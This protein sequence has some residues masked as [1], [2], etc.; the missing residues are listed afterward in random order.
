MNLRDTIVAI[1]TPLGRGGLGI[2]RL[3]GKESRNI[4]ERILRF[5]QGPHWR[6]WS[7]Q[8]AELLD[9]DDAVIDQVVVSF[10][11]APR[12]Y[13][14]EDVVEIACHGAPVV[15]RLCLERAIEHGARIAEPGEF[16]LRAYTN[17]RIDLPRAEAIR[18]LIDATTLYQARVAAQQMEGSVSRR[19]APIKEQLL[20]LISLLEAGIDFAEDD[21]SVAPPA[22]I[23]RRLAPIQDSLAKLVAS[24]A[25]GK[26]VFQGFTLAIAG[27]PNVGKSSLF[28][29]LLEQDR[30]IVTAIPGTTRD[31]VSES[32]TIAG[33]PVKLM[34][35]AGIREGVDLVENLGIERTYQA[36]ADADLTLLVFD[37][38]E[39]VMEEDRILRNKLHD[40][41]PLLVGNKADLAPACDGDFLAVSALTGKGIEQL[42]QAIL[43]RLAPE[44]LAAPESGSITSIRHHALLRESL[45]ALGNAQRAVEFQIPHEMLLL[46]LYAALR[47]I[48]AVTGATTAD[49][50][51]N[52]IFSTFCIGK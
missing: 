42:R 6:S 35:T 41:Q 18:E 37:L 30:A 1:A 16:T 17:G 9:A 11:E 39:P 44:G 14:A 29:R 24:F 19:V 34:D 13:T 7:S 50:I 2:V 5:V 15:L 49:D 31:T 40:R 12:S 38:S 3:S 4:A 47:P 10:F 46:D 48:D 8:F 25:A 26:L 20:E 33:V 23:L 28:N 45:E 32:T 43:K 52:R 22:E 21:I 51:L 27:R 36:M